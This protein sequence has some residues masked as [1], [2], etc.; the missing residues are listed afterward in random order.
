[1]QNTVTLDV[2]KDGAQTGAVL[3]QYLTDRGVYNPQSRATVHYGYPHYP[4]KYGL[5]GHRLG[6]VGLGK[7]EG[8]RLMN[9]A[10]C[11]TV[12]YFTA[13]DVAA[14]AKDVAAGWFPTL[15]YPMLARKAHGMGGQDIATVFQPEEIPW[16]IAAGWTWF[17][18]YVPV[19]KEL[20]VWMFR[21]RCLDTFEKVMERPHDYT[22]IGRN[23]DNGFQF[24]YTHAYPEANRQSA[25][26]LRAQGLDFAAIDLLLGKDGNTYILETNTAPG[27][28]KSKAQV[29]VAK[30]AD[31]ITEWSQEGYPEW[32]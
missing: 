3:Q 6:T 9:A 23:F 1:M 32:L 29:T 12:P 22:R 14:N 17:S 27:A 7:A 18:E 15:R 30:L 26:A 13:D 16:R 28:L 20:R 5:N 21:G 8:M 19:D 11:R 2:S 31:C 4:T 10:G 24:Q 25:L